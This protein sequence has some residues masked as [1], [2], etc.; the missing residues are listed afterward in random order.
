MVFEM[1]SKACC[2]A[3]KGDEGQPD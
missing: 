3:G 1:N 2:A